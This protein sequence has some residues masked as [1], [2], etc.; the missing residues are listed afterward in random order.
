MSTIPVFILK[1]TGNSKHLTYSEASKL[2]STGKL[3]AMIE[4][5]LKYVNS[6]CGSSKEFALNAR[7]TLVITFNDRR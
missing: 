5:A 3:D 1:S 7:E 4:E 6:R 2:C